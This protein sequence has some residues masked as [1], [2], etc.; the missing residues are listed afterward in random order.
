MTTEKKEY[1]NAY[2]MAMDMQGD[3]ERWP[4]PIEFN[5][6]AER[7]ALFARKKHIESVCERYFLIHNITPKEK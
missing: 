1:G 4:L 6:M 2:Q 5:P 3:F 7:M